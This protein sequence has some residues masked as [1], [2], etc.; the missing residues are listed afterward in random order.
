[1]HDGRTVR[2]EIG[3]NMRSWIDEH[4]LVQ[5]N[6]LIVPVRKEF[7]RDSGFCCERPTLL[8]IHDFSS[9]GWAGW[10]KHTVQGV[11]DIADYN[12]YSVD[13]ESGARPPYKQAVSNA[14]VVAL[15][16][17]NLL[18]TLQVTSHLS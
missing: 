18:Q 13:W 8:L 14:R 7:I 15:E 11:L 6:A 10:I 2:K 3:I 12:I 5:S 9:N 17:Q 4:F 16:V 1:M